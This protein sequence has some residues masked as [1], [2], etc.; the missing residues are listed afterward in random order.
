MALLRVR[1]RTCCESSADVGKRVRLRAVA[2]WRTVLPARC[3][4]LARGTP[5]TRP[6]TCT[7][8]CS[9]RTWTWTEHRHGTRGVRRQAA[10]AVHAFACVHAGQN[11]CSD[12]WRVT[13]VCA[14]GA[15]RR[16]SIDAEEP[17]CSAQSAA[18]SAKKMVM[19]EK[20]RESSSS[21]VGA[22]VMSGARIAQ[23]EAERSVRTRVRRN[24]R[25]TGGTDA[26][27]PRHCPPPGRRPQ[28][29]RPTAIRDRDRGMRS[30]TRLST[31]AEPAGAQALTWALLFSLHAASSPMI[32]CESAHRLG[33][34][35]CIR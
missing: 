3:G 26:A 14:S 24:H 10:A 15:A 4:R 6:P 25:S 5:D 20:R 32:R 29:S 12:G 7:H 21:P 19:S 23:R 27:H 33:H 11:V 1:T 8:T 17:R 9:D 2:D 18:R 31:T 13:A 34:L 30:E 28:A 35:G 22:S 16:R